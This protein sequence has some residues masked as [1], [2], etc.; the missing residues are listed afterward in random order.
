LCTRPAA[1]DSALGSA[2]VRVF[3]HGLHADARVLRP[4]MRALK[5]ETPQL[6]LSLVGE[7]VEDMGR[8]LARELEERAP[9]ATLDL[10]GHSLGGLVLRWLVLHELDAARVRRL[11]TLGAPHHGSVMSRVLPGPLMRQLHPGSPL[12]SLLHNAAFPAHVSTLSIAARNDQLVRPH[13]HALLPFG[14]QLVLELMGHGGLLMDRRAHDAVR[15]ALAAPL[16]ASA[17]SPKFLPGFLTDVVLI[18][19]RACTAIKALAP[20]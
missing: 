16:R 9:H 15:R 17:A 14:E 10:V 19:A 11:V 4:M 12:L 1:E 3:V 20:A 2:H 8:A 18:S 13:H 6:T 5:D 7:S